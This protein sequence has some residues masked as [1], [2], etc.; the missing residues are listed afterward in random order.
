MPRFSNNTLRLVASGWQL[1]P[2]YRI[3]SGR[4]LSIL[5]GPGVDSARNGTASASQP[6]DQVLA[7]VY[8]DTSGRPGTNCST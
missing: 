1:A 6:T 2:I 7:N 3:S 8:G 5:A 4:P